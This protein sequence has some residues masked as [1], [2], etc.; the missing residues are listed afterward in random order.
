MSMHDKD[1]E[2]L[3]GAAVQV[4]G[5]DKAVVGVGAT[6]YHGPH[7]PYGSDTL[8]A[9]ELA[10]RVAAQ[11]GRMLVLP[12]IAYGMSWHHLSFPWTLSISPETL[13]QL[14]YDLGASLHAHQINKL[15][16]VTAHDG[17]AA[18]V[19]MAARR[20]HHDLGLHVAA[21]LGWQG[22]AQRVLEPQGFAVDLNHAGQSETAVVAAI[23][24]ELVRL[25]LAADAPEEA[26]DLPIRVFGEYA[27]IAPTG[28]AGLA[29]KG[30]PADGER[31]LQAAV[32]HV[33]PFLHALD[34][35]DW[36]PGEWMRAWR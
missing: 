26:F 14:V 12:P 19:E 35:H 25:D 11:M 7:L 34:E 5:Y 22:R 28:Y 24:P 1:L 27:E 36:Q 33:L 2:A 10:R 31:I 13:A 3:T 32:E 20:L 17:N 21:M 29:T 6:E 18:P 16:V 23:A 4:G 30:T 15:L 8:V 9:H